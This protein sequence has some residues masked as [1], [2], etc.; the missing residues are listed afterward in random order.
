MAVIRDPSDESGVVDFVLY[1]QTGADGVHP[2][3]FSFELGGL[4]HYHY[5]GG[6]VDFI[7]QLCAEVWLTGKLVLHVLVRLLE[8]SVYGLIRKGC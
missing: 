8:H 4:I 1:S 7:K 2:L 6:R 3:R 5:N